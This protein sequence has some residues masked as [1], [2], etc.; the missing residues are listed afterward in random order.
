MS[1]TEEY[2]MTY[3]QGNNQWYGLIIL[4]LAVGPM[5]YTW[6]SMACLNGVGK[7]LL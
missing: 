7:K 2:K 5:L 4:A 3:N 1:N 6:S